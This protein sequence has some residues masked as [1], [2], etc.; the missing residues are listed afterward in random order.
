MALN[1]INK[2]NRGGAG[3]T[4]PDGVIGELVPARDSV[5]III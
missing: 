1:W 5:L 4:G 3:H 2:V